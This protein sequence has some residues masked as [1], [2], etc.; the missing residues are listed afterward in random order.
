MDGKYYY[1]ASV[2]CQ[3]P[4]DPSS[5]SS[6]DRLKRVRGL[7]IYADDRP[8][9]ID[10]DIIILGDPLIFIID[11]LVKLGSVNEIN[12][13]EEKV[14]NIADTELKD[15]NVVINLSESTLEIHGS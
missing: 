10:E 15:E 12:K 11:A 1:K 3:L 14:R 7:S 4:N 6:K 9:D 13:G 8:Q 5:S 2:I